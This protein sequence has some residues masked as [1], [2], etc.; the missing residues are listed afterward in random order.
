MLL[1]PFP[2]FTHIKIPKLQFPHQKIVKYIQ[3]GKSIAKLNVQSLV[4]QVN[5]NS[6]V[7]ILELLT[8]LDFH[9]H[10]P[11]SRFHLSKTTGN[12]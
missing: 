8:R 12:K 2:H 5:S 7:I 9:K 3:E 4:I 11:K 1:N 10:T 6:C